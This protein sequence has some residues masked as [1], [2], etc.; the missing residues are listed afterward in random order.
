RET[1]DGHEI[2][3]AVVPNPSHLEFVD[4]VV[5]GIVRAR[6]DV[7]GERSS[8]LAVLL[9]GDAA[10]AGEGIVAETLNLSQL[11]GY[12]TGGT[13]HI[14]TNNQ[15]GFTTPPEEGRSSTYSTDIAKMIQVPIF[16]INSDD[17]EAAYNVL[18]IALDYRRHFQKDVVLDVIGFRRLG[19]NEGDEPTYTQPV[20]YQRIK[21]HP[22]VRELYARKLI[23]EG[24][25]SEQEVASLMDERMRRYENAQLGAKEIIARQGTEPVLPQPVTEPEAVE[26]V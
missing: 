14:V 4:P 5:E 16:H 22:G 24:V 6:Q 7:N 12:K 18:Q 17:V 13:I 1:A 23:S 8:K 20:M 11:L 21:E 19:H 9:H 3:L 25:M 10:F 26:V 2:K 15:L